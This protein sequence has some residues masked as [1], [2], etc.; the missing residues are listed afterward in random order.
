[1]CYLYSI[2]LYRIDNLDGFL[3]VFI[4]FFLPGLLPYLVAQHT[5]SFRSLEF[6]RTEILLQHQSLPS[7]PHTHTLTPTW[8][9]SGPCTAARPS[10]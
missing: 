9:T 3:F 10:P 1:M 7:A 8:T 2:F 4:S 5:R 6:P